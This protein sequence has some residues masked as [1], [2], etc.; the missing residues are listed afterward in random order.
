MI[1][2]KSDLEEQTQVTPD[3]LERFSKEHGIPYMY[4]SAKNGYN[5][6]K[7]FMKM[8][9]ELIKIREQEDEESDGSRYSSQRKK[10]NE[11]TNLF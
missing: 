3:D 10:Y 7:A 8:T 1:V 4:T 11:T 6:D 5:V 9:Q 2:N